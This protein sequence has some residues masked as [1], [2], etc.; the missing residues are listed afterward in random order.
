VVVLFGRL[1]AS[2]LNFPSKSIIASCAYV[3]MKLS[4]EGSNQVWRPYSSYGI[5]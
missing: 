3:A 5:C 1:I 2:R 4:V